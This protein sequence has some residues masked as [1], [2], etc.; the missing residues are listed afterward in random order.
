MRKMKYVLITVALAGVLNAKAEKTLAWQFQNNATDHNISSTFNSSL[1]TPSAIDYTE[2]GD[3]IAAFGLHSRTPNDVNSWGPWRYWDG[4]DGAAALAKGDYFSFTVTPSGNGITIT[5]MVLRVALRDSNTDATFVLYSGKDGFV[6]P[7]GSQTHFT[8]NSYDG[9]TLTYPIADHSVE[10]S[11]E[12]RIAVY[13]SA[14]SAYRFFRLGDGTATEAIELYARPSTGPADLSYVAASHRIKPGELQPLN[15]IVTNSGS[16]ASN[17]V[18]SLSANFPFTLYPPFAFTNVTLAAKTSWT[19][20]VYV[21]VPSNTT[22]KAYTDALSLNISGYGSDGSLNTATAPVAVTVQSTAFASIG[23]T[24]FAAGLNAT[25]STTLTVSN[26]AAFPLLF[27][28]SDTNT[29]LTYPSGSFSLPSGSSTGIIII[30]DAS[31][32]VGE[33]QYSD[34]L[35]V[36]W[37]NNGSQPNPAGFD[38]TFDVGP[39]V[40]YVSNRVT[41]VAGGI[42]PSLPAGYDAEPGMRLH[43]EVFSINDGAIDVSNVIN[44]LSANPAYFTI[45]N[46]TSSVY[47]LLKKGETTSTVYQVDVKTAA[48]DG[49]NTFTVINQLTD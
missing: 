35:N 27:S 19:N 6:T 46:L 22:A 18:V 42:L 29:W 30:A 17:V 31:L 40:S 4:T 37:L 33:G 36:N 7:L 44:T 41:V 1:V 20:T 43:V 5:S 49:S 9:E 26:T 48:P 11:T 47:T 24:G 28:L 38:L 39:K 32:T 12:F 25:D 16:N 45:T 23:K 14:A 34:T 15:I 13:N 10:G 8:V 2:S 3:N 21:S